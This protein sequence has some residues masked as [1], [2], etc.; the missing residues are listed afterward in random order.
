MARKVIKVELSQLSVQNAI[1][2]LNA[3]KSRLIDKNELFVK[4]LAET[5]VPIVD[6]QIALSHGDSDKE[7]AT[8][9]RVERGI[10]SAK[11]TLVI[12]GKDILFIEFGA[13][14]SYN[15][16]AGSSPHPQGEQYGYTIGSYGKG[17]GRLYSWTYTDEHGNKVR[18]HGTQATFPVYL[19]G[20]EIASQILTIAREVFGNG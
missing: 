20:R 7:H 17:L 18:S 13:G 14:I 11:A 15:G 16:P 6:E 19:A 9:I 5:G 3:L 8:E 10:D 1:D 2:E 4:R 12:S